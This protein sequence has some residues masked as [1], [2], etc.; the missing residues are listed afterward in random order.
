MKLPSDG[1]RSQWLR[2]QQAAMLR[3]VGTIRGGRHVLSYSSAFLQKPQAPAFNYIITTEDLNGLM[4]VVFGMDFSKGLTLILHTP[5]GDPNAAATIVAYLRSK[6]TD[7][8]VIIPTYA[9]SAGTMISLASDRIVMGRQSQLGPI[10]PQMAIGS[11]PVSARAIVE[12]FEVAK[13]EITSNLALAHAWAPILQSLGPA[14]LQEAQNA[15][16]YGES[17]VEGWLANYMFN[18]RADPTAEGK[19]VAHYFNDATTHKSHG[20]RIGRDEARAQGV[21]VEDLEDDQDLQDAV[22]TG[23]HLATLAI[24]H[25]IVTKMISSDTDRSWFKQWAP[26]GFQVMLPHQGP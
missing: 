2:D 5:G 6:F 26:P 8:E 7:I 10:D 12:Q 1:A 23:Y 9:M 4:S 19:R 17:M 25:S 15:L 13:G 22:L 21:V 20:R 24:E 3:R 14:L 18:G 11:R 16:D